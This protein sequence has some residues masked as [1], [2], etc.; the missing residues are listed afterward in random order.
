MEL[1]EVLTAA[2]QAALRGIQVFGM[3]SSDGAGRADGPRRRQNAIAQRASLGFGIAASHLLVMARL[4]IWVIVF[5]EYVRP[6]GMDR[7]ELF[8]DPAGDPEHDLPT[9]AV[10]E[11][12]LVV[13]L[14]EVDMSSRQSRAESATPSAARPR[15]GESV[16]QTV[17]STH[18]PVAWSEAYSTRLLFNHALPVICRTTAAAGAR[19]DGGL[20]DHSMAGGRYPGDWSHAMSAIPTV[21][22]TAGSS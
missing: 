12:D 2:M 7:I 15:A 14:V 11:N 21:P 1:L 10:P 6:L 13:K 3:L 18:A 5:G 4:M 8:D 20:M 9:P 19:Y 16:G 22:S 17:E